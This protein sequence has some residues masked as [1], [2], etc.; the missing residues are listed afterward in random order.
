MKNGQSCGVEPNRNV[1]GRQVTNLNEVNY[2]LSNQI[3]QTDKQ[4][5]FSVNLLIMCIV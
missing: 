3:F 4:F 5:Q 2:Q 1:N